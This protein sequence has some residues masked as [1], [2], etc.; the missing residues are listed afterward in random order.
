MTSELNISLIP[1]SK[2]KPLL[3]VDNF[4][5]YKRQ[6]RRNGDIYW[7]CKHARKNGCPAAV[8]TVGL[9]TK[10]RSKHIEHIGHGPESIVDLIIMD[11]IEVCKKRVQKE[12]LT[13]PKIYRE[14]MVKALTENKKIKPELIARSI[15]KFENK[16][17]GLMSRRRQDTPKLPA[18]LP[19]INID[20]DR[21]KLTNYNRQFIL[22]DTNDDDR[23]IAHSSNVQF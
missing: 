16:K 10:I 13:L 15:P 4:L 18:D 7:T 19:S 20:Q 8:T 2:S 12:Q 23:I 11:K 14:E 21:Y 9:T 6:E 17:N 22:F 5:Y 1:S 3:N